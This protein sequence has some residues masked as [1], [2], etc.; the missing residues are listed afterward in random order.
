M[1][2][3][4]HLLNRVSLLNSGYDLRKR[5]VALKLMLFLGA[6]TVIVINGNGCCVF[7]DCLN[8]R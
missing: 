6:L 2:T 1:K 4:N 8:L 3:I 7:N 5:N